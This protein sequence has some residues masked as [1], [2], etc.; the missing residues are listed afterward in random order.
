MQCEQCR[1][2][3]RERN[4]SPREKKRGLEESRFST[5]L[6]PATLAHS[7]FVRMYG[8]ASLRFS[9]FHPP[10]RLDHQDQEGMQAFGLLS[11]LCVCLLL[12]LANAQ[13]PLPNPLSGR[14]PHP[15]PLPS[16]LVLPSRALCFVLC[17]EL[18]NSQLLCLVQLCTGF[19]SNA[20]NTIP[21]CHRC[22]AVQGCGFC[23]PL[24]AC[25][26]GNTSGPIGGSCDADW[27]FTI[28][29]PFTPMGVSDCPST[30]AV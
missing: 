20:N 2:V 6:T 4:G 29:D 21:S 23:A 10:A 12:A 7:C 25:L 24:G 5:C 17:F 30:E 27:Y 18:R 15:F 28:P 8:A 1:G 13:S 19:Y 14:M 3:L 9:F 26:V 22:T 16:M 11:A